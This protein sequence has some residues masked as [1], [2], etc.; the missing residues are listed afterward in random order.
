[1]S[2]LNI[3]LH[4]FFTYVLQF[5]EFPCTLCNVDEFSQG[6]VCLIPLNALERMAVWCCFFGWWKQFHLSIFLRSCCH[7]LCSEI[8]WQ[9]SYLPISGSNP[10]YIYILSPMNCFGHFFHIFMRRQLC[11]A[12]NYYIFIPQWFF[13]IVFKY[14][15]FCIMHFPD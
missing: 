4:E 10:L 14:V 9:M 13:G 6:R 2:A 11:Q 7:Y 1:M 15:K 12:L 5:D 3:V 8:E